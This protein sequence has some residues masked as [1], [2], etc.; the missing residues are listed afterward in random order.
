VAYS[1][2]LTAWKEGGATFRLLG[3]RIF[4]RTAIVEG[5]RPLLLIHGYPTA[6][7]DWHAVWAPLAERY[8]LYALDM[9]G[10]GL[11]E[12]PRDVYY[13]IELQADLC[14]ALLAEHE[15]GSVHVLAHDYGDTV[16]QELLARERE[17]RIRLRSVSFLNGGLFPETHR[18]RFIQRLLAMR[19]LGPVIAQG[20]SYG[21]FESTMLS[22]SGRNPPP[23]EDLRDM[24]SL[25]EYD[26]GQEAV[27]R[28]ITY[29]KQR[30]RN[31]PRWVGAVVDS[32]VP[33]QLI[34]G[35]MDPISGA[36]LAERYCELVPK[37]NVT[38]LRDV[39]H[40]PQLEVPQKVLDAYFRFRD[41]L[42]R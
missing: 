18:P 1:Q 33:R 40:Y 10:F 21:R 36:H 20:M 22:I 24:W 35:A 16:A 31:R 13:A 25:I 41:W 37:P 9:L 8:S 39:G 6:S 27:A 19:L 15:V 12:K 5:R 17:G 26:E 3:R 42:E 30:R 34:C 32:G 2:K 23:R 11:S 14:Q 29:M 28:L 38:L 7:Y 4:A